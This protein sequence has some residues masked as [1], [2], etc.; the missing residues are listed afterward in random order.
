[1]RFFLENIKLSNAHLH[2]AFLILSTFIFIGNTNAQSPARDSFPPLDTTES[3]F[4]HIR[5]A[6]ELNYEVVEE[7][8]IQKLI[9]FVE[10]N[11]DTVFI[12]CDSATIVNSTEVTA[13]GNFIL[14][15]GDST[16]IFADSAEY[17]SDTK[18][19]ELY[20][21]VSMLKGNQKLFTERLSYD[22]NTKI[23][24][25]FTGATLTDDTTF[26]RSN[27]GYF[28]AKTD[29]IYFR[30][31]VVVV[32]PD[33]TLRSDTLQYNAR[34]DLVTFLAPTLITQDTAKIYTES[35]FYDIENKLA[36]FDLNPQYV[37]NDQKAWADLMRWDGNLEEISL[38]GNAHFEDS[39]SVATAEVIRHNEKTGE[40]TLEGD[41]FFQDSIR[42]ITGDTIAYNSKQET[43]STRGR[44]EIVDGTNVLLADQVDYDKELETSIVVGNVI[45]EDKEE[46]MTVVCEYAEQKKE[47]D[48]LK[49]SGGKFGRPLLI[50]VVDG[51]SMFISADTLVTFTGEMKVDSSQHEINEPMDSVE[52]LVNPLTNRQPQSLDSIPPTIPGFLQEKFDSLEMDSSGVSEV[53]PL[54]ELLPTMVEEDAVEIDSFATATPLFSREKG[55]SSVVDSLGNILTAEPPT[56]VNGESEEGD[57]DEEPPRTILAYNDVK[58]FKSDLQSI[59][60]SLSYTTADSTFRLFTDPIIWSDTSQFTADLVRMQMANNAIDKIFMEGNSFIVNSPDEIFFNQIKG[61]ESIAYFDSSELRHVIVAGNAESVY[62]AL[63]DDKNYVGVN[64][65]LCSEMKIIFGNNEVEG[66][67]F[68]TQPTATIFPMR[69][70]DH[71]GELT[72]EGFSWQI[73]KRPEKWEDVLKGNGVKKPVRS[74]PAAEE[75]K[76]EEADLSTP[77]IDE[78]MKELDEGN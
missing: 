44:A 3:E 76:T 8:T 11:Q 33:F 57:S 22:A 70:A 31:S 67:V 21:N 34:R 6:D 4:I 40:T 74:A 37:K 14:Q 9:G 7:D 35:G 63:D 62:Y 61:R 27:R 19:A 45:F 46:Q 52:T 18:L 30:D 48:Y 77:M 24:S 10:M 2:L 60:D 49:A 28:H 5:Y 55:D 73:E 51:D 54:D 1:M 53:S 58:I 17:Q 13:S 65:T 41:G 78:L 68:Y 29:D 71:R 72:M 25:Y 64:K 69:E 12:F 66:I 36:E 16:T 32:N 20:G 23:A 38:I 26:L 47:D 59:C 42:T 50:R 15:Q 39:V 43:Y 56:F 75:K